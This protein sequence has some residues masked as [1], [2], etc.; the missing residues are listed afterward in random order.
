MS[1]VISTLLGVVMPLLVDLVGKYIPDSKGR[2]WSAVLLSLVAG[3]VVSLADGTVSG[4]DIFADSLIVFSV[5]QIIYKQFWEKS[6][7]RE[8]YLNSIG[9]II[10][11]ADLR[12][13]KK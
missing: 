1:E 3:V 7:E 8:S 5:S 2:F 13:Q 10:R 11:I 9:D 6:T 12:K 4:Q